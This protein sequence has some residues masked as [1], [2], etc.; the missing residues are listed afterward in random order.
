MKEVEWEGRLQ[1]LN[2]S[3]LVVADGAH[4]QD[5]AHKLR[6]ALEQYFKYEKA[7]LIIGMSSDKD[8]A[9]IVTELAPAFQKVIVTRAKHP[10]AM[11]TAP[12]AAE[13]K[14][15]GL[16]A[17]QTDDISDALPLALKPRREEGY[18]LCHRFIVYC[19]GSN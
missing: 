11:A 19:G 6:L 9:G 12:I 8:L 2:R 17:Q 18:D 15:H 14:K 1:V 7:L 5:S 3:P 4:N 10:R 13:F 16:E